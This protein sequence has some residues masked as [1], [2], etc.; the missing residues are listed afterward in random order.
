MIQGKQ[1]LAKE[2]SVKHNFREG[3]QVAHLLTKKVSHK[4]KF[5]S[6]RIKMYPK[7]PMSLVEPLKLDKCDTVLCVKIIKKSV[8]HLLLLFDC[9]DAFSPSSSDTPLNIVKYRNC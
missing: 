9:K 8:Y 7:P 5:K 2:L 3:N 6:N 4:F 1:M